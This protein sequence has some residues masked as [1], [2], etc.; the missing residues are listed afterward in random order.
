[1]LSLPRT[2]SPRYLLRRWTMT[3]LV[4]ASIGVGVA[5]L[6]ATR[7]LS[8]NLGKAAKTA[9]NPLSGICDL[10]V[11]GDFGV[12]RDLAEELRDAHVGGVKDIHP[13]ILG[14][15]TIPE[16]NNRSVLVVGTEI[17]QPDE[18]HASPN[19]LGIEVTQSFPGLF[20]VGLPVYLGN[21]L[22]AEL[23]KKAAS[24]SVHVKGQ[25]KKVSRWGTVNAH[26]PAA[27]LGG[28]VIFMD[29]DDAITLI[30]Q[31]PEDVA[32][33]AVAGGPALR[34]RPQRVSRL[35]LVVEPGQSVEDVRRRVAE[36]VGSRAEVQTPA[37]S[38]APYNDAVAGVE[39]SFNIGGACALVV[40]LFLV[41]N[42]LSVS[43]AERRH[44]IGI[45]RSLGATRG[46]IT[47]LFTGEALVLGLVGSAVG[48][49]LGWALAFLAQGLLQGVLSESVMELNASRLPPLTTDTILLAL[50]AG[51]ATALLASLV[52]A[53]QAARE[54]PAEAVRRAPTALTWFGRAVHAAVSLGI[55]AVG[56]ALVPL[57]EYLPHRVSSFGAPVL[58][59]LGLLVATPL[60]AALLAR[61]LQP[62]SR[63]VLDVPERLA[64]DNLARSPGR[65]G[66]VIAALAAGVAL[67]FQ[68]AGVMRSSQ[69]TILT[70]LDRSLAADLVVTANSPVTSSG[71][72]L[73]MA[74]SVGAALETLPEVRRV[75]PFRYHVVTFRDRM[76]S[77]LAV[78]GVRFYDPDALAERLPGLDR[79]PRLRESRTVIVSDNFAALYHVR[80]GDTVTLQGPH[81]P[82]SFRVI[83]TVPD[84]EW[85]RGTVFIDREQYVA[86]FDDRSVDVYELYLQ[87]GTDPAA[88]IDTINRK[89]GATES[90]IAL[91][92]SQVRDGF[93]DEITKLY[94]IG[95][96]QELVVGMVAALGVVMALL[97]SV[98]QRRRELGLLRAVGATQSQLLR[99]VLA[100][101]T[102]MGL[103]GATLGLLFGLPMEWYAVRIL[104][105]EEAGFDLPLS[106]PWQEAALVAALAV[107]I[108][109]VAGL[110]PA[111][112]S[113]R[114]RIADAIAYE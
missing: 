36:V 43:V 77:L 48:L 81:G 107:L 110:W 68:T 85:N 56:A 44:D 63:L 103:I 96:A 73:P 34:A 112:E 66:L 14:S 23:G 27:A 3:C 101:A 50:A 87:R 15:A 55:I 49:P 29:L 88:V 65:T 28:S 91:T 74:E 114:L 89:W 71:K 13:L 53:L 100:E 16:L 18:E 94:A 105:L 64:A 59:L 90:L 102:L 42:A 4:V 20:A 62:I 99:S 83:G 35:D 86:D 95:Y 51:T 24:F 46:Q 37:A 84:Y 109:T 32:A 61:M 41:Y 31:R 72:S 58:M 108:A 92:R 75:V 82:L 26:G 111:L 11:T 69:D 12:E 104:L 25:T 39:L 113:L 21:D 22:S 47:G 93:R 79:F 106:V 10:M 97:I 78:D 57:R 70:W 33:A 6:V 8:Q 80:E 5:A 54:E 52:P 76:V 38:E 45:L 98:L 19:P 9:L 1:M 40:G 67:V 17:P 30:R 2:L 60:L 7:A